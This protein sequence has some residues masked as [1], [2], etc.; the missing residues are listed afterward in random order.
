[1]SVHT[2]P[3]LRGETVN[4][5]WR[6]KLAFRSIS[7]ILG[8]VV[9]A[10]MGEVSL[11]VYTHFFKSYKSAPFRQYDPVLG[12]SLMP[13]VRVFHSRGCFEGEVVTNRWG[14]RDRDRSLEKSPGEF[15]IALLG[16]SAVEA[17]QVKPDQVMNIRMEKL[18]REKGYTNA[19]VLAFG[20]EG[21][22]TTQEL[23]MY[24]T[25]VRQFHPDLVILVWEDNDVMNNSS[26]IQPRVYGIHTWYCP[27]YNL[28]P[29]GSLVFQ[30][31]AKKPFRSLVS[32]FES[33]S[34]LVY[35]TERI[36]MRANFG[37]PKWQGIPLQWGMYGDPLDPEWKRAWL[38]T[39]KVLSRFATTVAN[40][41]ARFIVVVPPTFA[42]TDPEWRQRFTKEVGRIPKAFNPNTMDERL[43]EIA[44]RNHIAIGFLAPYMEAYRDAH[45]LQWPYF[46]FTCDPH[47]SAQGH[48]VAA[49]AI[50][51]Q[52]EE[53]RLPPPP[54]AN[55]A[56][57]EGLR[58]S[59]R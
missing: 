47:Y 25:R 37:E 22:G 18:L 19:E 28:G 33:H 23:L 30:P 7:I 52:L 57:P 43:Q 36:W 21:I 29:D 31:V 2:E 54:P 13:N 45:K 59:F 32:F 51:Q 56:R 5:P 3:R 6:K 55:P 16:D 20:A 27:Y 41:G 14:W 42:Q 17:V 40:D 50:V 35:Y 10:C 46:S 9:F 11:R 48:E 39:E 12:I 34:L 15:R 26:T 8:L 24:Q 38:L 53:H 44:T 1:V 49:E 4:L 58:A